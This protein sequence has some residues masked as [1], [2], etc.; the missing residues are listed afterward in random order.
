LKYVWWRKLC[1]CKHHKD[2]INENPNIHSETHLHRFSPY[3]VRKGLK[4]RTVRRKWIKRWKR[5][6][7]ERNGENGGRHRRE[8]YKNNNNRKYG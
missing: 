2:S 7:N 6:Q 8:K 4:N 3:T 5:K 1:L